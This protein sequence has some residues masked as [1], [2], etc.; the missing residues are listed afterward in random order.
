MDIFRIFRYFGGNSPSRDKGEIEKWLQEDRDGSRASLYRDVHDIYDAMI[1]HPQDRSHAAQ[2]SSNWRTALIC[3]LAAAA[4]LVL[5]MVSSN[6]GKNNALR[7]FESLSENVSVPPGRTLELTLED[8]SHVWM[9]SGSEISYP[10]MFGDRQRRLSLIKGEIM[11][12]VA[13]DPS[14]PFT[15]E[16]ASADVKVYGTRFNLVSDS[17]RGIFSVSLFRG[18]IGI[19]PKTGISDEEILMQCGQTLTLGSDGRFISGITDPSD[20]VTDWTEGL[21]NIACS[22]FRELMERLEKAFGT[23]IVIKRGDIPQ[24]KVSRGRVRIVDGIDHALDVARLA[25]DFRY[26]HDYNTDTI[27]IL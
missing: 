26:V 4:S 17:D 20:G 5:A 2:K 18:S 21:V 19:A 16:T 10:K 24:Y 11:M 23:A 15:I 14:R 9:N 3:T 13:K 22:D 7:R 8:G 6:V 25:A 1:L 27:T 12:D